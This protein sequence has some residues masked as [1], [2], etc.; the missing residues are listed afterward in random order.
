MIIV[1]FYT[2]TMNEQMKD[3][4]IWQDDTQQSWRENLLLELTTGT[5]E[6]GL[7]TTGQQVNVTPVTTTYCNVEGVAV[8]DLVVDD[9]L[10]IDRLQLEVDGDVNEPAI[11]HGWGSLDGVCSR[12]IHC[13]KYAEEVVSGV[14]LLQLPFVFVLCFFL[15]Q[16]DQRADDAPALRSSIT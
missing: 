13:S 16:K 7:S 8:R 3:A 5:T 2:V 14:S 4:N 11:R 10:Q 1:F 9:G 6:P 15:R 12:S